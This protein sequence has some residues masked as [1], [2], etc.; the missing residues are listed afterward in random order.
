MF[1]VA[2]AT[3][4]QGVNA[5]NLWMLALT[6]VTI[7]AII[8]GPILAVQVDRWISRVDAVRQR[9]NLVF[10]TLMTT[11]ATSIAPDHVRALNMID[12]AW[13]G[14]PS[15]EGP[16]RTH[17]ESTVL[18]AWKAY[19]A[20][21]GAPPPQQI[22]PQ[23]DAAWDTRRLAL[24]VDL[25]IAMASDLNYRFDRD[26]IEKSV[27]SPRLHSLIE[28]ELTALRRAAIQLLTGEGHLKTAIVPPNPQA[29]TIG[30][31]FMSNL[32]RVLKAEQ[33]LKVQI[34]EQSPDLPTYLPRHPPPNN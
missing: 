32:I 17:S 27:Y 4:P 2:E 5:F 13:Y 16:K 12:L 29:A 14:R 18:A 22:S 21:L 6:V 15:K 1:F 7:V 30:D 20:H 24:L 25:L 34:E 23:T 33:R 19:L 11:R 3:A 31:E 8:I 26:Q 10:E 9:K 28:N